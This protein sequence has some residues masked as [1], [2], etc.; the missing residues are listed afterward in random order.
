MFWYKHL[1]AIGNSLKCFFFF[2]LF[3]HFFLMIFYWKARLKY[4]L[5]KYTAAASLISV[6]FDHLA[7]VFLTLSGRLSSCWPVCLRWVWAW[8]CWFCLR[9]WPACAAVEGKRMRKSKGLTPA[10][11]HGL[12]LSPVWSSGEWILFVFHPSGHVHVYFWIHHH[13]IHQHFRVDDVA[14]LFIYLIF[15]LSMDIFSK[16]IFDKKMFGVI[17]FF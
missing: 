7:R 12:L 10:V 8:V 11:S 2:F 17:E 3:K 15:F 13:I 6:W 4:W 1:T 14:I 9:I 16:I 5:R